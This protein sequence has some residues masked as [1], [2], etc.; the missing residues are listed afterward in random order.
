LNLGAN[1]DV[2]I[3]FDD[4]QVVMTGAQSSWIRRRNL[5]LADLVSAPWL[6]PPPASIIGVSMAEAFRAS[7]LEPPRARVITFSVPLCYQLLCR[8]RF[9]A[10]LPISIAR[11]GNN[12]PLKILS[13]GFPAISRPTGIITLKKRTLSPLAQLF[14]NSVRE[15]AKPLAKDE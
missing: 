2:E 1:F 14:I 4:R 8:G 11:L 6:L 10:M 15:F 3:L 7:G 13:V 9:L 12:L 5:R